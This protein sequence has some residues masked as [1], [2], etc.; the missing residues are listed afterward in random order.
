VLVL[1]SASA[2]FGQDSVVSGVR[3]RV[4]SSARQ[5]VAGVKV[6]AGKTTCCPEKRE[7]VT[8]D[9]GGN[10]ELLDPGPL[11]HAQ[12]DRF[13]PVSRILHPND[14]QIELLLENAKESNL[15]INVCARG[16]EAGKR[17]GEGFRFLIPKG[18]RT[19][20]GSDVD[21]VYSYVFSGK[22]EYALH[23][24]SGLSVTSGPALPSVERLLESSS[25]EERWIAG[26][27]AVPLGI[28][29]RG[30]S[31]S[32]KRWRRFK[33]YWME[34]AWYDSVSDEAAASFDKILDSICIGE[35]PGL[36]KDKK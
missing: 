35:L 29:A 26:A 9:A 6:Y 27:G 7:V 28:D 19:R 32:G 34:A 15:Q 21:Y 14:K 33:M 25:F 31:R 1:L 30:Q 23:I 5:P 24:L 4:I 3:G 13:R 2:F 10:F 17:V 20:N 11:L 18:T 16:K 12:H 8:T 36:G 22:E